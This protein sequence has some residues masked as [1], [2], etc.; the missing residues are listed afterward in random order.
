MSV[1][2]KTMVVLGGSGF[3]GRHVIREAVRCGWKVKALARSE[4]SAAAVAAAGAAVLE[5]GAELPNRWLGAVEGAD[6]IVDLVQPTRPK[7]VGR[8]QMR[9]IS[10]QRQTFTVALIEALR[11]LPADRRPALISVS[12]IDDLAPDSDGF[13]SAKSLLR[14]DEL[15][16]NTIGI[17]VREIIERSGLAASFVYLGT[18]YGSGGP[19]GDAILPAVAAGKWKNFGEAADRMILVHVE[20]VA[21]GLVRIA[22]LDRAAS[23]GKSFVLTDMEPVTMT[24]VFGMAAR[25]MGVSVPGSIPKWLASLVAGQPIVETT[26]HKEA[27][28]S[29]FSELPESSLIY[30]SF[31]EGLPPTL[32][33]LGYS[34]TVSIK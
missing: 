32:K 4:E 8:R 34:P 25:L 11:T 9:S 13:L 10:V 28:R 21:R 26:L 14:K 15:G 19:F 22:G 24:S 16:F 5:G 6:A 1:S 23:S 2:G 30:P 29:T 18:V 27:V 17:P 7:R 12:G 31:R 33:A 3:I 20:D